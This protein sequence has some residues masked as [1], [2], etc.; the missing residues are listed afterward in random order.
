LHNLRTEAADATLLA[1]LR[2]NPKA[3]AARPGALPASAVKT[4]L[5]LDRDCDPQPPPGGITCPL[6]GTRGEVAAIAGA[7][8]GKHWNVRAYVG[9]N[10]IE[11]AVTSAKHPRLLL[12]ATH[13]FFFSTPQTMQ[14]E[15]FG[16]S[17][18]ASGS[19]GPQNP[20]LL[21]G[22]LF[23]GVDRS[24][25]GFA[26]PAGAGSGVLTAYDASTLNLQGTQLVVLSACDTGLGKVEAGEGV[27]GL[28]RAF[29]EA[30]AQSILMSMWAVPAVQTEQLMKDFIAN[31]LGTAGKPPMSEHAALRLAQQ[32][33]RKQIRGKYGRDIPYYWGAWVL[34]GR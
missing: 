26:P 13:G 34:A 12:L 28:R 27:F 8:Q 19:S 14:K 15:I 24:R 10:A 4:E 32:T 1:K 20:M 6:P 7:L 21:S 18:E 5:G 17:P 11:E 31:W 29:E 30:G 9:R 22:L 25:L 2:T 33:L 23:A 16:E 3:E